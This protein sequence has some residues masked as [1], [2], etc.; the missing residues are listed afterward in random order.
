[1]VKTCSTDEDLQH[2]QNL[3]DEDMQQRVLV[4]PVH[5]MVLGTLQN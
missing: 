3:H 1:M 2:N 4:N 5:P